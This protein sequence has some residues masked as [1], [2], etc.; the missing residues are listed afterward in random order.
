MYAEPL[1]LLIKMQLESDPDL[2]SPLSRSQ[3]I[4][5]YFVLSKQST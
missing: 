4:D 3:L 2:I 1:A 5:D